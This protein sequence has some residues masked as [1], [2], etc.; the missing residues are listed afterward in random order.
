MNQKLL[1]I[2]SL[3]VILHVFSLQAQKLD[4]KKLE[5]YAPRNIG[6]AGM[7]GRV[8]TI[9]VVHKQP[10]IIYLGTASGG[11]WKSTGGGNVWEP[12]F[13]KEAVG[14]IGALTINQNN[15]SELWVGT[16]EGNPRNSQSSGNGVY[17]SID[18]GK[19]WVHLGLDKT[20]NIHRIFI[21]P[22]DRNTIYVGAIGSAWGDSK[23][24]GLYK[25]VDG[26]KTWK[27]ILY[28][29]QRTGVGDM[30]IDPSNPNK[31]IVAMW[32]YRRWPWFFK[33]GGKGSG[34]YITLDGGDNWKKLEPQKNGIPK[35]ELGRTGLA[36]AP[37][38]PDHIYALI[39]SK[40]N[41]LYASID[42][43]EKWT[44]INDTDI[45]D[46]PF[47]YGDIFVDTKNENRLYNVFSNVKVS[48]DGGKTFKTLL[49]WDRVHGDHHAWWI[50]PKNPNFI[51]NGNDGGA[52]IS[53]DRGKTWRFIEN[54]PVGQFYHIAIDMEQ[55]YNV[56]GGMQD[57]G[58]WRG[59]SKVWKSGGIR[60]AEWDEVSFGD[61][62][63]VVP[64]P[65]D[66]RYL[67]SM[68][69][70]GNLL[71]VDLKTGQQDYIRPD[72]P[73]GKKLRFNWSA[74]IA[75]DPIEKGTIYYGSQFVH[76]TSDQGKTW[77]TISPDLTSNDTSK[78]KQD[79]SGGLTYDVTNA[80][81][82]TTITSISPSPIKKGLLWVGTDDGNIQ[83]SK[84]GGKNWENVALNLYKPQFSKK[85]KN[86]STPNL[87]P[88][89]S[90]V[91]QV[92]ASKYSESEAFVVINDYRRNNWTPYLFH[93]KDFGKTWQALVDKNKVWGYCLS[94]AQDLEEPNLM[95][96]GTEF[97]LY[98]SFDAG[99]NWNRW[100]HKAYPTAS[101]MDMV[102]HPRDHDLVVGTFG[103]SIFIL[104]DI[105]P[106]RALTKDKNILNQSL[107][108]FQPN[109][110]H[111]VYYKEALGT[112]FSADAIYKGKNKDYGAL[113]TYY[114]KDFLN[115]DGTLVKDKTKEKDTLKVEVLDKNGKIIRTLEPTAHLGFNRFSWDLSRDA[116]RY[117]K[118]P[119]PKVKKPKRGGYWVMPDTYK[120][121]VIYAKDTVS[122][123][124]KVL[125]D[126]R[127]EIDPSELQTQF[128]IIEKFEKMV[129]LSTQAADRLREADKIV[130]HLGNLSKKQDK[131]DKAFEDAQIKI[132]KQLKTLHDLYYPDK[133]IQGIFRSSDFINDE[134][135]NASY[136]LALIKG[137]P[138]QT[139][140]G[141]F[142]NVEN[143]VKAGLEK[144]NTFFEN[145][146][147][148]YKEKVDKLGLILIQDYEIIS[149]E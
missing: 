16:G 119:K 43:G 47:Y 75:A 134:L 81:N 133:S 11:V 90:W 46:R 40:K 124:V 38:N 146:W 111:Q 104:D 78:Q 48:D 31:I 118:T 54:L 98:V 19:T 139:Q 129:K 84:D 122:T 85:N 116:F 94:F 22:H 5:H 14:S 67:Y 73:S 63:D 100:T 108:V 45:G 145:D 149:L 41:A 80:E 102:I 55:P 141:I 30:V 126:P 9:D 1:Y 20:R 110:A 70:G 136:R 88:Q 103:R 112:R 21:D 62:F 128:N 131:S 109:N 93:T 127:I 135:Q 61:G 130:K 25:T 15:P 35:G 28:I 66:S 58:S 77:Q 76:K 39:E 44:K 2:F 3:F 53:Y 87:P 148:T 120:I 92:H 72:D 138:Y 132:K 12:I 121:R 123:L 57:N 52:A 140:K 18:G 10:H 36:I 59:P 147:K 29:N 4:M 42:G 33:S 137:K 74:G 34:I 95:F 49:G 64:D 13:E 96:L 24:R 69:Q 107:H 23:E 86:R 144:V 6:P 79:Q 97:G 26:G 115:P 7:S 114:I 68:W 101:T 83:M 60:N 142:K 106:L 125:P 65:I 117:P 99:K 56:L 82:H 89:A 37:S 105:K 113:I 143:K 50:H 17:K 91:T 71:H 51:I 27:K 32:E 8:T